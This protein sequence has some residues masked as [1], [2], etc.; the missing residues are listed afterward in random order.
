MIQFFG[1]IIVGGIVGVIV[2]AFCNAAKEES[3]E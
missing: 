1:G 3:N 2:M